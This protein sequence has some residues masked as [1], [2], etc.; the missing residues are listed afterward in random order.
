[1]R[2]YLALALAL[3]LLA[4]ILP[5]CS[6]GPGGSSTNFRLFVS[7]QPTEISNFYSVNVTFSQVG[8]LRSGADNFTN[9]NISP[10]VTADLTKLQGDNASAIWSGHVDPGDYTKVFVYVDSVKATLKNADGS[11]GPAADVKLPSNKLQISSPFTVKQDGTVSFVFDI[12]IVKAGQSGQY[13]LQPQVAGS[14]PD[15]SF[16]DVT[17]K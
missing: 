11:A 12:T 9:Y 1:M 5:A 8:V 13:I 15:K 16:V 3:F 14:G 4:A 17:Q 7:D 2:K 10:S 6:S